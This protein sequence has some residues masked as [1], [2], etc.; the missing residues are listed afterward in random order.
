MHAVDAMRPYPVH[1]QLVPPARCTRVQLLVRIVAFFVLGALGVSF[2]SVFCF[3]Y[4][5]LPVYAAIRLGI[6]DPDT[7][8]MRDAQRLTR[9]LY[10]FAAICAWAG[11]TA[12]RLPA[13]HPE[14]IVELA[15]APSGRPTSMAALVRIVT[16]IPSAFVLAVL[17]MVGA[18][19]WLWA[20]ISILFHE[21]V[22]EGAFHFLAGLQRWSVRLLAYQAALVDDYPPF[23]FEDAERPAARASV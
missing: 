13:K 8:A 17:G 1:Y 14:E 9:I 4:V 7:Y 6:V 15:I 18:L 22:G 20:A 23:S 12:E 16:G 19:V 10:W 2:G 3:A 21:R 11:L 5:A